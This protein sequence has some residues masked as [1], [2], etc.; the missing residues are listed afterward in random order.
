MRKLIEL[1]AFNP[2]AILAWAAYTK[3]DVARMVTYG[4]ALWWTMGQEP[5]ASRAVCPAKMAK[6]KQNREGQGSVL[7]AKH[8]SMLEL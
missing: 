1:E 8:R 3:A 7:M 4:F 2:N 5:M 6:L